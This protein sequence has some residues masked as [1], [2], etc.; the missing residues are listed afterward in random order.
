M[1]T[2]SRWHL[3]VFPHIMD[4]AKPPPESCLAVELPVELLL[5]IL[6]ALEGACK[7]S[8]EFQRNSIVVRSVCRS[9]SEL[10]LSFVVVDEKRLSAFEEAVRTDSEFVIGIRKVEIAFGNAAETEPTVAGLLERAICRCMGLRELKLVGNSVEST[11]SIFQE[12]GKNEDIRVRRLVLDPLKH[13][14][15]VPFE[16]LQGSVRRSAS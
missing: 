16:S 15:W 1:R 2:K 13:T 12:L 9:W 8:L 3:F 7:S 14:Y 11:A 4:S 10:P 5:D 6:S